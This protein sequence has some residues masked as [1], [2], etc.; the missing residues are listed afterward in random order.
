MPEDEADAVLGQLPAVPCGG[1][2]AGMQLGQRSNRRQ[3]ESE[4]ELSLRRAL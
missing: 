1:G 4:A 2:V 3:Q